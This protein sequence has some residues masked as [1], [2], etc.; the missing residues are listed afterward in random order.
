MSYPL[1][2]LNDIM[3]RAIAKIRFNG[4]GKKDFWGPLCIGA[5]V[6]V[7][8]WATVAIFLQP[9][10]LLFALPVGIGGTWFCI[11]YPRLSILLM[12]ALIPLDM[13]T[14]V[15]GQENVKLSL[16]K[17]IAPIAFI[18]CLVHHRKYKDIAIDPIDKLLA[19]FTVY[20]FI[21]FPFSPYPDAA[22]QFMQKLLSML[23][24]YYLI[25]FWGDRDPRFIQNLIWVL[26]ISTAIS[27]LFGFYSIYKHGNPFSAF[28]DDSLIRVTGASGISPNDYA[29]ILFL[30]LSLTLG[31]IA[32]KSSVPYRI[33][34]TI[35]AGA[36]VSSLF[37]TYSRSG[38]ITFGFAFFI[39]GCMMLKKLDA[40][41]F[42]LL[43]VLLV[44]GYLFMPDTVVERMSTLV[45]SLK[46]KHREVS[47]DR[48]K[49]Y[50]RVGKAIIQEHPLTGG[51]LG[52]FPILHADPKYQP[53][54]VLYGLAR[55]PH[56]LYLQV[57]TETGLLGITLFLL[58]LIYLFIRMKQGLDHSPTFASSL[59][60]AAAMMA[61]LSSLLMGFFLH[62]LINK[63]FW[64]TLALCRTLT[65]KNEN[66]ARHRALEYWW[67]RNPP[68]RFDENS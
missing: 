47:L 41:V 30:P 35:C 9:I 66:T 60:F 21:L 56:N 39:L 44:G 1:T 15:P 31:V 51:G 42:L 49:N 4:L 5:V 65:K 23:L 24:L 11:K 33:L 40:R 53:A 58:P 61:F 43:P 37:F 22:L 20:C 26:I 48:R 52:S 6:S 45:N 68:Q 55:M 54:P 63:S 10:A 67:R 62:L 25:V 14:V 7:C 13:F 3:N 46:G 38:I 34:A 36:I 8:I 57:A 19:I 28:Q 29:Y 27:S 17:F 50:L 2:R 32:S 12:I 59:L 18:G 16:T 64:I